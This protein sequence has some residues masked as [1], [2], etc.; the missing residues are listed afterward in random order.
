[1]ARRRTHSTWWITNRR[2][3]TRGCG[4]SSPTA[5]SSNGSGSRSGGLS[6]R[7]TR[8]GSA[9]SSVSSNSSTRTTGKTSGSVFLPAKRSCAV[10]QNSNKAEVQ[11]TPAT[12]R[13][14][15]VVL[16][17]PSLRIYLWI[18]CPFKHPLPPTAPCVRPRHPNSHAR[19]MPRTV[20]R[21]F[22]MLGRCN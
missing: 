17:A 1:M 5:S 2:S 15:L 8:G 3:A 19:Q 14:A 12:H 21:E 11:N 16:E 6:R 13:W 18:E 9:S 20:P 7:R 10:H 4:G 22:Y